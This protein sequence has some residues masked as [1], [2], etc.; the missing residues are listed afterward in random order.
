MM[1][2]NASACAAIH[3]VADVMPPITATIC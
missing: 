2:D 3:N 1:F